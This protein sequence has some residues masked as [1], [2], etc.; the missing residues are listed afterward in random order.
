MEKGKQMTVVGILLIVGLV[1]LA[2]LAVRWLFGQSAT[3][4]ANLHQ[5]NPDANT[6]GN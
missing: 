2:L 1:V 6:Q 4:S 5:D 3:S